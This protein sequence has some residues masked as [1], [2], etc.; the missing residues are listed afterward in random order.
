MSKP[1]LVDL[2]T[3]R[4]CS[5]CSLVLSW[6][7]LAI[8]KRQHHASESG[9]PQTCWRSL[10]LLFSSSLLL[11]SFQSIAFLSLSS[12]QTIVF[13][14]CPFV[15]LLFAPSIVNVLIFLVFP[16]YCVVASPAT[17]TASPLWRAAMRPSPSCMIKVVA[18]V[19]R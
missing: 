8:C 19:S 13:S 17:P 1:I 11:Y 2:M 18:N 10:E 15:V 12:F 14:L 6:R 3:V 7:E 4:A 16:F 5:S 9:C